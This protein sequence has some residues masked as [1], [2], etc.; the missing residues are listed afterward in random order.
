MVF[1]ERGAKKKKNNANTRN[2]YLSEKKKKSITK[3]RGYV[4]RRHV[5]S[6]REMAKHINRRVKIHQCGE[7]IIVGIETSPLK[8]QRTPDENSK[9]RCY[10]RK[11]I[12]FYF[13]FL[14]IFNCSARS[15]CKT[16]QFK[17]GF[18][19]FIY[20]H[21]IDIYYCSLSSAGPLKKW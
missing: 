19:Y 17:Y 21:F 15:G 3:Q 8:Y 20:N 4:R 2:I 16:K 13:T 10:V 7:H 14:C 12:R 5:L 11:I 6:S 9:Y 18:T 1:I